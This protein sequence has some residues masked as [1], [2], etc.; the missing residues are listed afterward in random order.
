M[1]MRFPC[2]IALAVDLEDPRVEVASRERKPVLETHLDLPAAV[3]FGWEI[4]TSQVGCLCAG[5]LL[6]SERLRLARW[7]RDRDDFPKRQVLQLDRHCEVVTNVR[8]W[9]VQDQSEVL[10]SCESSCLQACDGEPRTKQVQ[11]SGTIDPDVVG[12]Q[13]YRAD[14]VC[15]SHV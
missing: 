3:H 5:E 1:E 13:H 8:G 10:G 11:L 14:V 15:E 7:A 9:N 2:R 12:K 4:Q 6:N